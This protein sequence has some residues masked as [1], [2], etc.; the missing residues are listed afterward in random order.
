MISGS[1]QICGISFE[2]PAESVFLISFAVFLPVF[3]VFWQF[4][5]VVVSNSFIERFSTLCQ[6]GLPTIC[7]AVA[8]VLKLCCSVSPNDKPTDTGREVRDGV[9]GFEEQ[10]PQNR[11]WIATPSFI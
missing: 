8:W 10:K 4:P 5:Y 9:F 3:L 11:F 1:N 7:R 2:F 6:T